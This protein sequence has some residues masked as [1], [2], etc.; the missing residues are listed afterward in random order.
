ML[1]FISEQSSVKLNVHFVLVG[2]KYFS[3]HINTESSCF[4]GQRN[5]RI[6]S[7]N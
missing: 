6:M 7:W 4:A 5:V 1:I 2:F 3:C